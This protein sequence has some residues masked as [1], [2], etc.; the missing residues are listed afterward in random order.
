MILENTDGIEK[1]LG[2]GNCFLGELPQMINSKLIING[3]G[4]ILF[5]EAGVILKNSRITFNGNNAVIYLCKNK[6]EYYLDVTLY[7]DSVLYMGH[8]NYMNGTLDLILSEQKHCFIGDNCLLS[9][10]IW[11]R[12]ADPHLVYDCNTNERKNLSKS[13]FI[14]DHVWIGQ[15]V[16]LLKGSQ[17]DSGSIIGAKSVVT[18]KKIPHNEAW[19]G[20][21]CKRLEKDIF[22]QEACVHRW[23]EE[24]TQNSLQFENF[25]AKRNIAV[26]TYKFAFH[27]EESISF[28]ELDKKL[29]S[30]KK[31]ELIQ[32][33]DHL[34][35]TKQ[36]NRF[37]HDI[38]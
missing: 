4:N 25:A 5:C 7:N 22:W 17:I 26:D 9:F 18:G 10:G 24:E 32:Y 31:E 35:H 6:F 16:M 28:T 38:I 12:N 21:P 3:S 1:E 23:C 2:N 8:N 37:V 11:I 15:D 34:S 36:K 19:G 30:K 20:N 33:L 13:V 29:S 14:G 27:Q